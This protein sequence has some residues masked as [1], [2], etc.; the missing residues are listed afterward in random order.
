MLALGK[1]HSQATDVM[2]RANERTLAE[3]ERS[4]ADIQQAQAQAQRPIEEALATL[5]AQMEAQ[6]NQH[7]EQIAA[8]A[9]Q[10][11]EQLEAQRREHEAQLKS[12]AELHKSREDNFQREI[13]G[14]REEARHRESMAVT[15]ARDTY[16]GTITHL[17]TT[18][19]TERRSADERVKR[20]EDRA[21]DDSKAA[22]EELTAVRKDYR[23]EMQRLED[24]LNRDSDRNEKTLRDNS[25]RNEK[26][27]RD[28]LPV[29]YTGEI[30]ALKS[31]KERLERELTDLKTELR[32]V[33]VVA[34]EKKDPL[35]SFEQ[36]AA[37]TSRFNELTGNGPATPDVEPE[38]TMGKIAFHAQRLLPVVQQTVVNPLR[39]TAQRAIGVEQEKLAMERNRQALMIRE[40]ELRQRPPQPMQQQAPTHQLQPPQP[41]PGQEQLAEPEAEGEETDLVQYLAE[42]HAA[43]GSPETAARALMGSLDAEALAQMKELPSEVIIGGIVAAAEQ[44][45]LRGLTSPEGRAWLERVYAALRGLVG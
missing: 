16:A 38:S 36:V 15:T 2:E 22:R 18:L 24:R 10:H 44:A 40:M 45:R 9:S 35:T 30:A 20:V 41:M 11:R 31:D 14:A 1:A 7:R 32:E 39:E 4:R 19:D 43:G 17:Q 42:Q 28:M 33:R 26:N 23:E 21:R 13:T 8:Q 6:G 3:A 37:L 5:R 12:Q 25:E 27:I 29:A 34:D